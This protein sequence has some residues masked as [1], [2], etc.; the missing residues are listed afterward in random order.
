MKN[1]KTFEQLFENNTEFNSIFTY[2]K[3]YKNNTDLEIVEKFL[4]GHN[5]F[6]KNAIDH[7]QLLTFTHRQITDTLLLEEVWQL[8][9]NHN[10]DINRVETDIPNIIMRVYDELNTLGDLEKYKNIFEF[11]FNNNIDLYHKRKH[12]GCFIK[13]L[14]EDQYLDLFLKTFKDNEYFQKKVKMY[15]IEKK[16]KKFK[17]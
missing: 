15:E 5:F 9:I 10:C 4:N 17:I 8:F 2:I 3:T 6:K 14:S 12:R 11:L 1:L 13:M 7:L 16:A